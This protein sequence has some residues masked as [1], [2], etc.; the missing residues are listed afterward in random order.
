MISCPRVSI[1]RVRRLDPATDV[2][3][4]AYEGT[5]KDVTAVKKYGYTILNAIRPGQYL[6]LSVRSRAS[7]A[8]LL[9]RNDI[10]RGRREYSKFR[11]I[12]RIMLA[13]QKSSDYQSIISRLWTS[14]LGA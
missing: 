11:D 3:T 13:R 14:Q 9:P 6:T 5:V 4:V 7:L 12:S 2:Q 8:L 1:L 10:G